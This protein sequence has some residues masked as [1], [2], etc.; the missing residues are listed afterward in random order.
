AEQSGIEVGPRQ[1]I[2]GQLNVREP[3]AGWSDVDEYVLS[4]PFHVASIVRVD[5]PDAAILDD[6][7]I[8]DSLGDFSYMVGTH[9]VMLLGGD[10][11]LNVR[12]TAI[13]D[14]MPSA[15]VP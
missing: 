9:G 4:N 8:A 5:A 2:C 1:T 14:T 13:N 6:I 15:G 7:T 10:G 12:L 3:E 11:T